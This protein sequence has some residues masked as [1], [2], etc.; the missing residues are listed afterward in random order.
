MKEKDQNNNKWEL[1][2]QECPGTYRFDGRMYATQHLADFLDF[3]DFR[4][5]IASIKVYVQLHDGADYL[6]VFYNK[7]LDKKIFVIDNLNDQMKN[8]ADPEYVSEY[9]YYTIM[10]AEDY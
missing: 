7:H 6:F 5:I 4:Y 8:E 3:D 9:N 2:P 10:L 1:L